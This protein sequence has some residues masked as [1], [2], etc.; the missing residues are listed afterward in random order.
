LRTRNE[1]DS[2]VPLSTPIIGRDGTE[3][4]SILLPKRTTIIID[5]SACNKDKL[6]WGKDALEW[7]P[8][9]WL[10]PLQESVSAARVPG[11]YA[12]M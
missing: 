1:N 11:I 2:V 8:E 10:K 5:F 7:K 9:R 3:M 6:I 4:K 12:N